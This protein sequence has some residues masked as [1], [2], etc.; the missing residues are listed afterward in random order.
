[1]K[2]PKRVID[3]AHH[4]KLAVNPSVPLTAQRHGRAGIAGDD[5][6]LDVGCASVD[7]TDP[8]IATKLHPIGPMHSPSAA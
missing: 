6:A 8:D 7:L 1:M 4:P 2:V 3:L 5:H